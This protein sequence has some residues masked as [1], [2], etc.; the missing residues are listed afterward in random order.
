MKWPLT[1]ANLGSPLLILF[2]FP[3]SNSL[4]NKIT[5]SRSNSADK[6]LPSKW[7]FNGKSTT[8]VSSNPLF[9]VSALPLLWPYCSDMLSD[10]T[11]KNRWD[12]TNTSAL[13]DHSPKISHN[14][15][16][17]FL[18]VL[19]QLLTLFVAVVF[20]LGP[21]TYVFYLFCISPSDQVCFQICVQP[22]EADIKSR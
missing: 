4:R 7:V 9:V 6:G 19:I 2:C 18:S 21:L 1:L 14:M 8:G 10:K 16:L 3:L 20:L 17:H 12:S 5:L 22:L 15:I 11:L 13:P